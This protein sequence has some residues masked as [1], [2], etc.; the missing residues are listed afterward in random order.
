MLNTLDKIVQNNHLL[1]Y[2]RTIAIEL[3]RKAA[4]SRC[5][6]SMFISP[7]ISQPCSPVGDGLPFRRNDFE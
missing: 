1:Y 4:A 3:G 6:H 5:Q 2:H 7:F